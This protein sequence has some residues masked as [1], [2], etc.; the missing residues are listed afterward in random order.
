MLRFGYTT[1]PSGGYKG[2]GLCMMVEILCGIMAG[3]S[4]GKSIRKWQTTEE[5]ANL[6]GGSYF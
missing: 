2:T 4:F 1:P 6:V 3:S 5:N